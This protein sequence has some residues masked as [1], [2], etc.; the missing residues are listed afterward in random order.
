MWTL[1]LFISFIYSFI[2]YLFYQLSNGKNIWWKSIF[3]WENVD[4]K[5]INL[6]VSSSWVCDISS[7]LWNPIIESTIFLVIWFILFFY[8]SPY[9]HEDALE[10]KKEKQKLKIS[11]SP[12]DIMKFLGK[13]SY[14]IALLLFYI[15]LYII[16][17]YF[18]QKLESIINVTFSHF[19]LLMNI[20]IYIFFFATHRSKISRDFLKINSILFS[21]IYISTYIYILFTKHSLFSGVDFSI[22]N[23][24]DFINSFLIVFSFIIIMY[25]DKV[26]YKKNDLDDA[27][28]TYFFSY[29]FSI[30]LFYSAYYILDIE[31]ISFWISIISIIYSMILFYIIARLDLF[32]NDIYVVRYLSLM[33]LYIWSFAWIWYIIRDYSNPLDFLF[34]I[35]YSILLVSLWF[36]YIVHYKFENYVS[37][38][39]WI[40]LIIFL[41]YI[42]I[43]KSWIFGENILESIRSQWVFIS[44]I[45]LSYLL[46]IITYIRKLRYKYDYYII[47]FTSYII[48]IIFT[49]IYLI[50]NF[51]LLR[52]WII[53]FLGSI[54]FFVSNYKL[55]S[56]K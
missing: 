25:Y 36:N 30:F 45:I 56:L 14:Y 52:I 40:L 20:L 9:L 53:L 29:V 18:E 16:F 23:W 11:I 44:S 46:I 47:H 32:Q 17:I 10:K 35:I 37:L 12:S 4:C 41:F 2:F 1:F 24:G 39:V 55:S 31:F 42:I 5:N 13:F 22:F 54:Y 43:F 33:F 38:V 21:I 26:Q 48:N 3:G 51:D 34:I 6:W 27:V 8:F 15:S 19:I 50:Y 7:L 28:I 49:I